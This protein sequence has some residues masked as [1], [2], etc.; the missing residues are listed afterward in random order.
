MKSWQL[1][2]YYGTHKLLILNIIFR[3]SLGGDTDTSRPSWS[4]WPSLST[5]Q[6]S[7]DSTVE[8][9]ALTTSYRLISVA[10]DSIYFVHLLF[11]PLSCPHSFSFII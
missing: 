3:K 4:W 5:C 9:L 7:E 2:F 8:V 10:A 1:F 6:V 11:C